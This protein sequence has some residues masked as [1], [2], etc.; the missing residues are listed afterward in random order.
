MLSISI[1][2]S[3]FVACF[4]MRKVWLIWKRGKMLQKRSDEQALL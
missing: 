3:A 2:V 4:V 1:L